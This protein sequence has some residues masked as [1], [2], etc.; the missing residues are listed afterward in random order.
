MN[1]YYIENEFDDYDNSYEKQNGN[2]K[3]IVIAA[4]VIIILVIIV[5]N[6]FSNNS[7][8]SFSFYEN[9]MVDLAREYVST[10]NVNTNKE[11]YIDVSKLNMDLPNNCSMLSGVIYDGREYTPYLVCSD[12]ESKILNNPSN[13]KLNGS[14][15]IVLLKGMG[16][17][18]LGYI[19]NNKMF[20]SGDVL[21]DEGVYNVY[22]IPE[23]GNSITIRKVIII[24]NPNLYNHYPIINTDTANEITL[25]KGTKY[26]ETP[27]AI[28]SVDG[29]LTKNIITIND[30]DELT[31][32]EYKVI[33]SVRNSLGYTTMIMKKVTIVSSLNNDEE[34]N[35]MI[36]LNNENITNQNIKAQVKI[37]GNNYSYTKLPNGEIT[38]EKEFE[39]EISENNKYEFIAVDNNNQETNKVLNVT[40]I[41]KTV[42][43]GTCKAQLFYNQTNVSV[44][45]TS[46]NYIVGYD[47]YVN[48]KSSSFI[49]SNSY[50]NTTEKNVSGVYVIVRDYIGNEAKI[51]C[52]TEKM[53]NFDPN[54][55]Q[56][57]EYN[58]D[59]P[60]LRIPISTALAKKGYT[61]NDL[62][63][64][65]YDR[66]V[67]AGPYTRY[68]VAAAAYGLIDCTYKMT[69][70]VLSYNHTSGKV[71][72]SYCKYNSDICGKLGI[73]TRWGSY[74]GQCA[75]SE[76]WH[77]LNCATFV[78]WSM[79]NGGMDMCTKGSA[80]AGITSKK[81]FPEA[82]GVTI[83]GNN[84]SYYSGTNLTSL[85]ASA[86]VRMIKP[87]DAIMEPGH[88]FVVIGRDNNA[89]Y[90]A[91]DG[92]Y[93]RKITYSQ[94]LGGTQYRILFL[95]K[96]YANLANRN[97]LYK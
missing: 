7:S 57:S 60:R 91:E 40:N 81:Y 51:T 78:R 23:T 16:Y 62:N 90:T 56:K 35:I 4:I 15:V 17:Y 80:D 6:K 12:Y 14:E 46:F 96:Y 8:H 3:Y 5:I 73:N 70:Y 25:E 79:C 58:N 21:S 89:I 75:T 39:Y 63:K 31:S 2:G 48:G 52:S 76:C 43:T 71:E 87:G 29:D 55:I 22:Y 44:N 33:Y 64:C 34:I 95:D 26:Y 47:Y 65:I 1:N 20:I 37:T 92:Y 50:S 61:V 68:G 84:A 74:G 86:L 53:S 66:V 54:G 85:G 19:G 28:D 72:G 67:D 18:E 82:D 9:K 93:T 24:N 49:A 83:K 69:G 13:V 30:V 32:G 45:I 38:R 42:P 41:D 97:N 77:G 36:S 88:T 59:K 10:Y 27:V 11:I 94:L